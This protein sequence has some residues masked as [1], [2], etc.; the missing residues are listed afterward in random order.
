M[1]TQSAFI[2]KAFYEEAAIGD[3][4][5]RILPSKSEQKDRKKI[6]LDCIKKDPE[7]VEVSDSFDINKKR[8]ARE[9][10]DDWKRKLGLR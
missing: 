5:C 1:S 2:L 7:E 10:L 6:L 3:W 8:K 4:T 9:I